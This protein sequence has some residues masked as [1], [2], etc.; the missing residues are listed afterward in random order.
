[1]RLEELVNDR[2]CRLNENDL[3]IWGYIQTHKRECCDI[4]IEEL[5]KKCCISRTTISRFTQKLGFSG[6]REFK[7][8]LQ[9]EREG[10][11]IQREILLDHVCKNF[12][13]SIDEA[14]NTDMNSICESIYSARR[15]FVYGTG[16][17]QDAAAKMVK[18]M[19]LNADKLFVA[20]YGRSELI[21]ATENLGPEDFVML[22][23]LSGEN[24]LAINAAK[25]LKSQGVSTLS[26]TKL[27]DNTLSGLCDRNL[28]IRTD[29]LMNRAGVT[30]ETGS[31]YFNL[32]EILCIRYLMY[33]RKIESEK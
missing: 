23:S 6:F 2:Y 5:A 24:E 19:F 3:L 20:L 17:V 1:M 9:M 25:R 14:K 7:I 16:E 21:M 11:A 12:E 13:K 30:F 15:L 33:I 22:I 28:Y 26:I 31:S 32:I 4:A 29:I 10:D 18:R 8:R 27:S